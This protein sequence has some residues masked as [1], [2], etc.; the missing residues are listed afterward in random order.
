[1]VVNFDLRYNIITI[2]YHIVEMCSLKSIE[3]SHNSF[4]S[5]F[6]I[7]RY[8]HKN[9]LSLFLC[10]MKFTKIFRGNLVIHPKT[11]HEIL[12]NLFFLENSTNSC[13]TDDTPRSEKVIQS[14]CNQCNRFFICTNFFVMNLKR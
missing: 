13:F 11:N 9:M 5:L 3:I 4:F 6:K 8:F 2:Y 1:M 12:K 14:A 10:K 7:L